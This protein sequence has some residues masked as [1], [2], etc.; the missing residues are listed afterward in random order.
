ML[1]DR[2]AAAGSTPSELLLSVVVPVFNQ[3]SAI[4]ENVE[5]IRRAVG[6]GLG[7]PFELIVVSDG[8]IDRTAERVLEGAAEGVRVIHYDRNLGKGYAIK[9]G[10]LEARGRYIGYIDA[11][12]DLDPAWIPQFVETAE[13]E[14]LDFA[15]GSKRHPESNVQYP[16]SRRVASWLYQQLVRVLFRLDVRDTQVGLKVFRRDVAE[17]VLPLLLVKRFAFDLELLAVSRALG[18]SRIRELPIRLDYRFTGSGVRSSAVLRA[19]VDTAAIF[20]RLRVLRY[21]QR[22]AR[23]LGP[24]GAQRAREYRPRVSVLAP[25]GVSTSSLDYEPVERSE[26]LREA[27]GELVACFAEGSVIAANW[28]A[29]TVPFLADPAIDAVVTPALAP[30]RGS[31]PARAAAAVQESRLGGG[32]LY[33][34]FT[35]GNLRLVDDFPSP[36][37]LLRRADYLELGED[38]PATEVATRL[39]ERGGTVVYTPETVVVAPVPPL[40]RPHLRRVAEYGRLRGRSLRASGFRTLRPATVAA[41]GAPLLVA[42]L[43]LAL[44][45]GWVARTWLAVLAVYAAAAVGTSLVA[46]FAYRS[47]A[48]GALVLPAL[49]ATHAVYAA[50]LLQGVARR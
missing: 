21:Y 25:A 17:Q 50:S 47:P 40:L 36:A 16:R 33:F 39:A 48:V 9:V 13:R 35:P 27:T 20:Y 43:P 15:I 4:A 3:E 2:A 49:P 46:A 31:L 8:S 42:A 26:S 32:S 34:R 22:R 10:A 5:T 6:E 29:A 23:L 41:L 37:I 45:G 24:L 19:L 14:S 38:V 44:L 18:F 11:D 1:E 7:A 30:S 12:L 28:L